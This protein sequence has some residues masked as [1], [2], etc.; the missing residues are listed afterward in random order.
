MDTGALQHG[1]HRTTGDDAGTGG[2][3]LQ[4]HDTGGGLTQDR[5]GDRR[6][7]ARHLEEV[8]L[9]LFDTLGDGRGHLLGLSVA[10]SDG[11]VTV[12]H[13]HQGGEAEATTT[14]DDLGDPVDGYDPLEVRGLLDGRVAT[15][16]TTVV[17]ASTLVAT[18]G[19]GAGAAATALLTRHWYSFLEL[20]SGFA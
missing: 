12:A 8:L 9:G 11:A 18:A 13:D 3:R 14:L 1:A 7:D 16:L 2:G 19:A 6:G 17:A 5:V 20:E 4:E 10:D 15:A